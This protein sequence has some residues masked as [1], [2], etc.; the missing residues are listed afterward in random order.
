MDSC[1]FF[2][3]S[4]YSDSMSWTAKLS[5]LQTVLVAQVPWSRN[6]RLGVSS[7]VLHEIAVMG[8]V[9]RMRMASYSLSEVS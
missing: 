2:T 8:L 9:D 5:K 7:S 3:S 6:D 4:R 1:S